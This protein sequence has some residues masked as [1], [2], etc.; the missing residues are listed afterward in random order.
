[1]GVVVSC[2]DFV[3]IYVWIIDFYF[4]P[5]EKIV[6]RKKRVERDKW[7]TSMKFNVLILRLKYSLHHLKLRLFLNG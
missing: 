6:N 5:N 3:S 7:I 4:K 1:M 2:E